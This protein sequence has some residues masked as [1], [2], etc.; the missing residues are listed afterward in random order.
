MHQNNKSYHFN[1]NCRCYMFHIWKGLKGFKVSSAQ[2]SWNWIPSCLANVIQLQMK[3]LMWAFGLIGR[4]QGN[5]YLSETHYA[6]LKGVWIIRSYTW[7]Q[8]YFL[9]ILSLPRIHPSYCFLHLPHLQFR[10]PTL[11]FPVPFFLCFLT[12]QISHFKL[13]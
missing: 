5:L 3:N 10:S 13:N 6:L 1:T 8:T 9:F 12:A 7:K 4:H 2:K 11:F